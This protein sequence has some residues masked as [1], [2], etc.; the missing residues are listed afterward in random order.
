LLESARFPT[1]G[2]SNGAALQKGNLPHNMLQAIIPGCGRASAPPALPSF[3]PIFALLFACALGKRN[4]GAAGS[5]AKEEK[6][7][8]GK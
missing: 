2:V 6:R 1:H 5:W 4:T 8:G 3:L 7:K